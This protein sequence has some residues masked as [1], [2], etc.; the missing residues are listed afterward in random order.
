[1]QIKKYVINLSTINYP[2]LFNMKLSI[3]TIFSIK[4]LLGLIF[5]VLC[6][7]NLIAFKAQKE[8]S[9][10]SPSEVNKHIK[11]ITQGHGGIVTIHNIAV[12][13]GGTEIL[14][15]EVGVDVFSKEKHNPAILVVGNMDGTRPIATE[16]TLTL[17]EKILED[18]E[19]Y[20]DRTWYILPMGNP[21]ALANYFSDKQNQN[22]RNDM[23]FND[24]M[25]DQ[26]DEDDFNDLDGNGLITKMRIKSPDGEW[27][28][29]AGNPALLRKAEY[30]DG[31]KGVYK[32]YSE[33]IDDDGDGQ[34]NEDGK[35]GVNINANFPHLFE[36][37]K[38]ANG[39]YPGST[40]ETFAILKFA[41][42]HPEIAMTFSF[43]ST[44]FLLT[45][46]KG[47]RSGSVDMEKIS[48][49]EEMAKMLKVD[50]TKTYSMKEIME[51]VQPMLPPGM[52][53]DEG[54]IASF[55]GLGAI[56]N[57]MNE[58]LVFY[59]KISEDY[60]KYLKDKGLDSERFDPAPAKGG[61]FE[62]WS[63]YH[64]GV[65]VFS[66]DLWGLPKL[67]E[68]KKESSGVTLESLDQM[69]ADDFIALGEDKI[70]LFLK[71]SGAPAEFKAEKI[72]EMMKGGQFTPTQMAGMMKQM[73]KPEGDKKK[74]D[75][76]EQALLAFS[77]NYLDGEGFVEWKEY[78]H[79]TLGKLEI[80]GFKPYIGINPPFEFADSLIN[81]KVPFVLKLVENL[82]QLK[83][84][85]EKVTVKG[86]GVY[87]L[88]VWIE[89]EGFLPF[90]TEMGK[91]NK[92][93]V[94]AIVT[95]EGN[96]IELLS[97]KRRTPVNQIGG[98]KAHK[99]TWL[100]KSEKGSDIKLDI[101]SK[102]AGTDSKIIKLGE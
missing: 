70:N 66:M 50:Y 80:G 23:P 22:S 16:A 8:D 48:I 27:I 2:K 56:V 4:L 64:L 87:Q 59:N 21:D 40:P 69:N 13:P 43:G 5:T 96:N 95:I 84:S 67:K 24:D 37:F 94:P 77:E 34:Y 85:M 35:G 83:F 47:G 78:D 11:L 6:S 28:P 102:T 29:V 51:L 55:L 17:L 71:E 101:I 81:L 39:L 88:D 14:M 31:E 7:G 89:N 99:L 98:K 10:K 52:L 30:K 76:R 90:C 32:L 20:A 9:Y 62:L 86:S 26:V 65:P 38:P 18:D 54:M 57:P 36:F 72:I 3:K 91:R 93:P 53:I 68:E 75:P 61:S 46:P 73:P 100:V 45:P 97:G 63:Y 49:P 12:S 41:Y 82:P 92:I 60:K 79:P 42:K 19:Y 15:I 33:G 25:D 44:N 1:M 74:G 58:D